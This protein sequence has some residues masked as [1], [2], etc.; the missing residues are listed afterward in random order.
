MCFFLLSNTQWE[1]VEVFLKKNRMSQ[2]KMN[3]NR[4]KK[5]FFLL[6]GSFI[7]LFPNGSHAQGYIDCATMLNDSEGFRNGEVEAKVV[8]GYTYLMVSPYYDETTDARFP[9]VNG[10]PSIIE[11]FSSEIYFAIFDPNC[12]QI[13]GTY[14]GGIGDSNFGSV[15]GLDLMVDAAGNAHI[16]GAMYSVTSIPTTDGTTVVDGTDA[17]ILHKYAPD[18]TLLYST[19]YG[20]T[21]GDVFSPI[22]SSDGTDTYVAGGVTSSTGFPT[23]DGTTNTDGGQFLVKYDDTGNLVYATLLSDGNP[24]AITTSNGCVIVMGSTSSTDFPTTDGTTNTGGID[25]YITKYDPLGDL[26]FSTIYGGSGRDFFFDA[27]FIE[28]DGTHIYVYGSTESTNFPTTDGTV[29]SGSSDVYVR[30]YDMAGNLIFS[31]LLGGA[32]IDI[33]FDLVLEGGAVYL[34]GAY[35]SGDF[36]V[37]VGDI[38]SSSRGSFL[39]KMDTDGNIIYARTYGNYSLRGIDGIFVDPSGSV[40]VPVVGS[41]NGVSTDNEKNSEGLYVAKINPDG[42]L[43]SSTFVNNSTGSNDLTCPEMIGDTLY[44]VSSTIDAGEGNTTDGTNFTENEDFLITKFVFCPEPS[45]ITVD[46]LS[47][48]LV[49]V[50]ENGIIDKIEGMEQSID[51]S[52]FP[53]IFDD[54]VA[55]AQSDI[56]LAYQWQVSATGSD[57]WTDIPGPL[58]QQKDYTPAPTTTD[59]YYRRQTVTAECCGGAII[60]TSNIAHV[61][62]SMDMAPMVEAGDVSYTCLSSPVMI[63]ATIVGGTSP[64]IYDWND[65][66]FDIEDPIVSP[67]QSTV[68]TLEVIDANGCMQSGQTTVVTY[69]ADAGIAGDVCAGAGTTIGGAPLSGVTIVPAGGTPPAG[70]HSIEYAWTPATG[71]SCSDC[72]NPI[73]TPTTSE[74]YTL[75]VT[76]NYPDGGSCQTTDMVEVGIVESPIDPGFAGRDTVL[77]FGETTVLGLDPDGGGTYLAQAAGSSTTS[78]TLNVSQLSDGSTSTGV[79]TND[80]STQNVI[81]NLGSVFSVNTIDLAI[82][83]SSSFDSD[84]RIELSTDGVNYT[85]LFNDVRTSFSA[86][87]K[88]S[89]SSP[90]TLSFPEQDVQYFR[91][92]AE[93]NFSDVG[94]GEFRARFQNYSYIWTPGTYIAT[95]GSYATYDAGTLEM[96]TINPIT[97]TVTANKGTCNFYD[98]VTVAVTEARAGEDGCGPRFLGREDRTPDIEETYSWVKI[99]DPG[100][101]TGTGDFLTATDILHTTVSAS[102]G[103][104]VGYELTVSYTLPSGV[105]GICKDTVIVPPCIGVSCD[106]IIEGGGCPDFDNGAPV[107]TGIPPNGDGADLWT[108]SWDSDLGMTGLDSYTTQAVMLTDN[109]TRTYTLTFTSVL[110]PTE[111]CSDTIVANS[112]AYS[113]P[114]INATG[115]T[116]CKGDSTNIGDPSNNPGLTYAWDNEQFLDDPTSN[117]PKAFPPATTDFILTATDNVTGCVVMDTLTVIVPTAANAGQDLNVCDN[118]VVTIGANTDVLGYTYSWEPAGAAWEPGSGPTDAMPEVFV[119]TTQDFYLTMVD[120]SGTCTT[121]DTVTVTVEALPPSFTL[122]TIDFCPSQTSL[123]LGTADGTAGGTNEVPDG[124]LYTWKPNT[125]SDEFAQNPTIN[126][127]LP[128]VS[129]TYVVTAATIG[130]C[131][132][133]ATQTINPIM[134]P[135]V[136]A[137]NST[138]CL[139]ASTLIGDD[140]ND[141]GFDYTW[142]SSDTDVSSTLDDATSLNPTFTPDATGTFI[143]MVT[144]TSVPLSCSSTAQVKITVTELNAPVLTPQTICEGETVQIGVSTN[145]SLQYQWDPTTDLDDPYISN[146]TF[147]GTVSTNYILTIIDDNG[148][149]AEASTSVTVN[150]APAAMISLP[151]TTICDLNATSLVINAG[152]TPAG[153]YAYNWSP[154]TFLDNPNILTP[155]FFIPG[156]GDYEYT[157]EVIDQTTGCS[158]S[159]T[160]TMSVAYTVN[161]SLAALTDETICEGENFTEANVTTSVLNDIEVTYQWYDNNGTD[162][163]GT[164][165]ISGQTTAVL[166]ALPT[167]VGT[168]SYR[169]EAVSS[170]DIVC[171]AEQ[172]VNLV[173]NSVPTATAMATDATCNTSNST[174]NND[175]SITLAGFSSTDTYLYS[176]GMTFD[177][178]NSMP[179]AA[180]IIPAD[181]IIVNNLMNP[182]GSQAYT[183]R[184]TNTSGCFV[185]RVVTLNEVICSPSIDY[186]D[187]SS[188][189]R[190]CGNEPCHIVSNDLYLGQSVSADATPITG[191]TADSDDDDGL[192]ISSKMQIVPGNTVRIPVTIYNNTG[193]PAYLR[194]WIDWNADGDFEDVGE[195]IEDNTYP[196]TGAANVV[197]VSVTVPANAVQTN[198]IALR[199]RLSTDDIN[200]ATPCGTG[201][202]AVDGEIEDYL[203]QLSC[204]TPVCVPVQLT[205]KSGN[206]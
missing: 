76:I 28:T 167:T 123:T 117:Y 152:I 200:S 37:T 157:L 182:T 91:F 51:G 110:D 162:N 41:T 197:L 12:N 30:K 39:V 93:T 125:V 114:I 122:P 6:I 78:G 132:Q 193:M 100:I 98:Q 140:T 94:I 92:T 119:A 24:R 146:P 155:T 88:V 160:T 130:G 87:T 163:T 52:Q 161:P 104:N 120:T 108:Y 172:T 202:C 158:I 177:A 49:M 2:T 61:Q 149:T 50:C 68:Y 65:G 164:A 129:T 80:G 8:N 21:T 29:S 69:E 115:G 1:N 46:T 189:L 151:D 190:P 33:P 131:N 137:G 188:N 83:N 113:T 82:L 201:T 81:L 53:Q 143:F 148:C 136:V 35:G 150:P 22:V 60:S 56:P 54:G 44:L 133:K 89:Q 25:M 176:T 127:P 18:G 64:F 40:I 174:S 199:A 47:T 67:T 70:E 9:I 7:L 42:T 206:P 126:T 59:L 135:P 58:A 26:V 121:L 175:G 124:Y 102:E 62:V 198:P 196:S 73:A 138:I 186:P 11:D 99:A 13:K 183:V 77:C 204:P 142:T 36:P 43:C 178:G 105:T 84:F 165:A 79:K 19:V 109:V 203:L 14:I 66:E 34:S 71:L 169:V 195:Q 191:D 20:G 38:S 112:P 103:G 63:D 185:D 192:A 184:I 31:T 147:S 10:E 128:T 154:T 144:K 153:S 15:Y 90:T 23:T 3:N 27:N 74:T 187:Y 107:L 48:T 101:T 106:V 55:T 111:T 72:P 57:P 180:M 173:I 96:P 205:R 179:A 156:E 86:Q 139:G 45:P 170:S 194:M 118:G 95:D 5:F 85:T 168:Y 97:Y 141:V 32:G 181:G 159:E 145:G 166:T 17:Y 75:T 16:V 116:T 171:T 4:L 134:T